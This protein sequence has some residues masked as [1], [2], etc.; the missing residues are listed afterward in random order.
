MVVIMTDE[1][2]V[3]RMAVIE[4]NIVVNIIL[5]Y[6]GFMPNLVELPDNSPVDIGWRY[7]NGEF[8]PPN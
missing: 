4:N 3:P 7:E 1:P 2:T 8:F 5:A 6:P